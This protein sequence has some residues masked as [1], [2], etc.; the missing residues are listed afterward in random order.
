[1]Q[2]NGQA[3]IRLAVSFRSDSVSFDIRGKKPGFIS[4][5]LAFYSS[6][7]GKVTESKDAFRLVQTR[8]KNHL[9]FQIKVH[10]HYNHLSAVHCT[11]NGEEECVACQIKSST[12]KNFVL[13]MNI[14]KKC[15]NVGYGNDEWYRIAL[16]GAGD[17]L[18]LVVGREACRL[19]PVSHRNNVSIS[20]RSNQR[21][22]L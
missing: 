7:I 19:E 1:M 11:Y 8:W 22:F 16:F 18:T 15:L 2:P 10:F 21:K 12:G 17:D 3:S 14:R 13:Q 4:R 20:G 6:V 9:N 5:T